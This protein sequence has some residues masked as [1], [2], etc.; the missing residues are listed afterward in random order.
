MRRSAAP[1]DL[2]P[3]GDLARLQ[4]L[5]PQ[6]SHLGGLHSWLSAFVDPPDCITG[7]RKIWGVI[8]G[9]VRRYDLE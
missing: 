8:V 7:E 5:V 4:S 9:I 6:V 3:R 1:A 2:Q